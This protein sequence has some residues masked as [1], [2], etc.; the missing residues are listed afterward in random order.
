MTTKKPSRLPQEILEMAGAQRRLG[1]MDEATYQK[2]TVRHL[3]PDLRR[4]RNRLGAG[5]ARMNGL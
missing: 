5:N 1:I 4:R 2:I 3:G